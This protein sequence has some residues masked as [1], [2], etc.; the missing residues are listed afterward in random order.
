MGRMF[1]VDAHSCPRE[2]FCVL[3]DWRRCRATTM[4]RMFIVDLAGSEL[5]VLYP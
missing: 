3:T 2:R 5:N 4:G 1:I